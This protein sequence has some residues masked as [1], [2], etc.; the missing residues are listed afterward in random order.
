M[1]GF[2]TFVMY[3]GTLYVCYVVY[4]NTPFRKDIDNYVAS[5]F[6]NYPIQ[7]IIYYLKMVGDMNEFLLIDYAFE[8]KDK[9]NQKDKTDGKEIETKVQGY[10]NKYLERFKKF[11]NE[12]IFSEEEMKEREE[13]CKSLRIDSENERRKHMETV[14]ETLEHIQHVN[15]KTENVD[16]KINLKVLM[17]YYDETDD[18][19]QWCDETDE[20][21]QMKVDEMVNH[22][23]ESENDSQKEL[24]ELKNMDISLDYFQEEANNFVLK[25][26]LSQFMNNYIIEST[27]LGNVFMRYND[28]KGSFEYFSNNTIPY[29]Y[30]EPIGRKYVM[31]YHCKP[32]FVDLEEELKKSEDKM[33]ALQKQNDSVENESSKN[34]NTVFAKFRKYNK[35]SAPAPSSNAKY[36]KNRGPESGN[37]PAHMRVNLPNVN[38]ASE[39]K[40]LKEHANRYTYEGRL[41]NFS[42]L[43]KIDRKTVDK[44]YAMTFADFKRLNQTKGK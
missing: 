4:V 15:K 14:L 22:L 21:I 19:E 34:P 39:K 30:L 25:K 9:D 37:M 24:D 23:K 35:D 42:I 11:S 8:D 36:S 13:K 43:K 3:F 31:I 1:N 26:K 27:P 40:M 44:K 20:L 29:R 28:D 32:L 16:L 17:E 33:K 2:D 12:Y 7:T 6:N 5:F 41:S 38:V 18:F 10:E